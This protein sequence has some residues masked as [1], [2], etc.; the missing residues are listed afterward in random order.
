M[1]GETSNLQP[2]QLP[3]VPKGPITLDILEAFSEQLIDAY[4]SIRFTNSEPQISSIIKRK[5]I[6]LPSI[7]DLNS[8]S[9]N[10]DTVTQ[11][12]DVAK[13]VSSVVGSNTANMVELPQ[14]SE[15]EA[16]PE[17]LPILK[18][19]LHP[20]PKPSCKRC[21]DYLG[22]KRGFDSDSKRTKP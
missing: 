14:T 5:P 9:P 1:E 17:S 10:S 4:M 12:H 7:H 18:C 3:P 2:H 20:K 6:N 16:V 15:P 21:Q 22:R 19:F 13:T 8:I 11:T